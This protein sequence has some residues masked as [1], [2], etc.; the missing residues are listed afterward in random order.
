MFACSS[1]ILDVHTALPLRAAEAC[2]FQ[3][4]SNSDSPTSTIFWR[5]FNRPKLMDASEPQ[6]FALSLRSLHFCA[7][8]SI[9]LGCQFLA[10]LHS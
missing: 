9:S 3:A 2:L 6:M 10:P 5:R 7:L 4:D 1:L 8:F